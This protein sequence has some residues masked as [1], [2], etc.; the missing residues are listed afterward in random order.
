LK[1]ADLLQLASMAPH[2]VSLDLTNNDQLTSE[3]LNA[4]LTALS[5]SPSSF[6]EDLDVWGCSSLRDAAFV[7][8]PRFRDSLQRIN[9]DGTYVT[10]ALFDILCGC[11]LLHTVH[12]PSNLWNTTITETILR[13]YHSFCCSCPLQ[14]LSL[15]GHLTPSMLNVHELATLTDLKLYPESSWSLEEWIPFLQSHQRIDS[16]L[17][18]LT[19]EYDDYNDDEDADEDE[20]DADNDDVCSFHARWFQ[21]LSKTHIT[22]LYI[23]SFKE[24]SIQG[25]S[26]LLHQPYLLIYQSIPDPN[27][28]LDE[29]GSDL[30]CDFQCHLLQNRI[31]HELWCRVCFLLAWMRANANNPLQDSAL[32]FVRSDYWGCIVNPLSQ[33][34][35]LI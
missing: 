9:L 22:E 26:E 14:L 33:F 24:N 5:S 13:A 8:L 25:E 30:Q 12:L 31:R 10:S 28:T 34:L 3:G 17:H 16:P 23:H 27:R 32:D 21:E 29:V 20:E 4:Y 1:D 11:P 15:R 7:Y 6:L 19:I 35:R 18:R 2:L